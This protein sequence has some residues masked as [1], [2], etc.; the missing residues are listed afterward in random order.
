MGADQSCLATDFVSCLSTRPSCPI[1]LFDAAIR[2]S[3]EPVDQAVPHRLLGGEHSPGLQIRGHSGCGVPGRPRD[4]VPQCRHLPLVLLG[5]HGEL[6][7]RSG[8]GERRQGQDEHR[9]PMRGALLRGAQ[10]GDRR[11]AEHAADHRVH[12]RLDE[13]DGDREGQ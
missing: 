9:M 12:R 13:V 8:A 10:D 3:A 1:H 2:I 4:D 5:E 6:P 11:P 7:G